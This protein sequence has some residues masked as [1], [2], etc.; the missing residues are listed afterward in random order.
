M[1][2]QRQ[3]ARVNGLAVICGSLCTLLREILEVHVEGSEVPQQKLREH[4]QMF[5]AM[6]DSRD[7][8]PAVELVYEPEPQ[9]EN[10]P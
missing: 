5:A 9:P 4:E 1:P 3:G 10:I 7:G 2:R 6:Q 8:L